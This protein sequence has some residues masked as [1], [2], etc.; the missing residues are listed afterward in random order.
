[1][2]AQRASVDLR[3]GAVKQRPQHRQVLAH[4]PR[5]LV[6]AVPVHVLDDDFVRKPDAERQPAGA[7]RECS[8][9]RL[10]REHRRMPRVT[11]HDGGPQLDAGHP[12]ARHRQC[13]QRLKPEDVRHPDRREAVVGRTADLLGQLAQCLGVACLRRRDAEPHVLSPSARRRLVRWPEI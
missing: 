10:L 9:Q 3:G 5:G 1:M 6:E 4:V 12:A 2:C 8:G 13:G 11:G 7:D